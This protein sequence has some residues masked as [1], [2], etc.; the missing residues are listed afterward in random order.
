M[1]IHN[2]SALRTGPSP[3]GSRIVQSS[4]E[5]YGELE[6]YII[7]EDGPLSSLAPG[8]R[9]LGVLGR[10][11]AFYLPYLSTLGTDGEEKARRA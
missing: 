9:P 10:C 7:L 11:G 3:M 8:S 1:T 6:G 5:Y 2:A 4:R